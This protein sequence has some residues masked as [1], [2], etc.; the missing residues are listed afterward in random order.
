MSK[1]VWRRP[2]RY[3]KTS[4]KIL[5]ARAIATAGLAVFF[6]APALIGKLAPSETPPL[7]V[8][9][10]QIPQETPGLIGARLAMDP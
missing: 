10:P 8:G 5:A 1:Q 6:L 4:E 7:A 3:E 9:N 2:R